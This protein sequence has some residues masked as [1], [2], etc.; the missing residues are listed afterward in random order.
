MITPLANVLEPS[1]IDAT[2]I[3]AP[4]NNKKG[5][6]DKGSWHVL[7]SKQIHLT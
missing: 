4:K 5:P 3:K 6:N 2:T 1:I 7:M